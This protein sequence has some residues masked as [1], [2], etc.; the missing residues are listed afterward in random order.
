MKTT[1]F[2][3][4]NKMITGGM[5]KTLRVYDLEKPDCD[6]IAIQVGDSLK[7]ILCPQTSSSSSSSSSP[8]NENLALCMTSSGTVMVWDLRNLEKVQ[9]LCSSTTNLG[10]TSDKKKL[11]TVG[12]GQIGVWDVSTFQKEKTLSVPN[13]VVCASLREENGN[14]GLVV[15]GGSDNWIRVFDYQT[16]KEVEVI[17]GH[18]GPVN[19]VGFAPDGQT[20]ASGSDDGTVRIW[21]TKEMAYGLWELGDPT[22][23]SSSS[24]HMCASEGGSIGGTP[25]TG[26]MERRRRPSDHTKRSPNR[27]GNRAQKNLAFHDSKGRG[28]GW[29]I[30]REGK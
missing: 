5:D 12:A 8:I 14:G 13:S 11:V 2:C 7:R 25:G 24:P 17:K 3:G 10:F 9:E 23:P 15:T 1:D 21:L 20:Y 4:S 28:G 30:N 19:C 6:P 27:S 29:E 16:E 22:T 18:H 26:G